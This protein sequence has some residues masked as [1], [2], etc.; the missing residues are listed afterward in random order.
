MRYARF[1]Y[2]KLKSSFPVH[3]VL[4][5]GSICSSHK[6]SQEFYFSLKRGYYMYVIRNFSRICLFSPFVH[7]DRWLN[8]L[9][10]FILRSIIL[11]TQMVPIRNS[12]SCLLVFDICSS[13][14]FVFCF[15]II[16]FSGTGKCPKLLLVYGLPKNPGF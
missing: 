2:C 13:C 1:I 7:N 9:M 6:R 16:L 15:S 5:K 14:I 4:F 10:N 8:R 12:L 11:S 3:I